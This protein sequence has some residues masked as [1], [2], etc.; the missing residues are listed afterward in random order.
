MA[1]LA[2]I[3]IG[4]ILA[5]WLFPIITT[6]DEDGNTTFLSFS[7]GLSAVID[8]LGFDLSVT[9]SEN[10]G[11]AKTSEVIEY[12]EDNIPEGADVFNLTSAQKIKIVDATIEDLKADGRNATKLKVRAA[13]T[14]Y[15][16]SQE[17]RLIKEEIRRRTTKEIDD[18]T[19]KEL[20]KIIDAVYEVFEGNADHSFTKTRIRRVTNKL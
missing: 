13:L 12:I 1:G 18:L 17:D 8:R 10:E 5:I 16:E 4:I 14:E 15:I 7:D 3:I 20:D 6:K 19:E 9:Y 2:A 11:Y